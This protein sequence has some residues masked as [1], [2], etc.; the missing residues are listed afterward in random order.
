MISKNT[1][2]LLI[3]SGAASLLLI[4]FIAMFFTDEVNWDAFDFIV[5]GLLLTGT[6][7]ACEI[8]LRQ[9]KTREQRIL[10]IGITLV[11]LFLVWVEMAVGIFGSPFAGS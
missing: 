10:G 7:L 6:G 1:R 3:L 4:P 2:L 11:V 8:L 5:A 9:F